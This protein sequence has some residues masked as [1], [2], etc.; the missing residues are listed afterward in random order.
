MRVY[1][2]QLASHVVKIPH[3]GSVT[4]STPGFV[5]A[6]SGENRLWA[7]VS[8]G[9]KAQYGMPSQ[10]VLARWRRHEATVRST[11]SQGAVWM[12]TNGSSVW[13]VLWK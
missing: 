7:V 1:G 12:R 5:D 13:Q 9:R 11:A 3:H 6:V 2:E 8:V 10:N 4:S